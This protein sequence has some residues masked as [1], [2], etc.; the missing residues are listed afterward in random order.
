MTSWPGRSLVLGLLVLPLAVL[1]FGLLVHAIRTFALRTAPLDE[2]LAAR[3]RSVLLGHTVRQGFAW[4]MGPIERMIAAGS[5]SP[6]SLTLLG[7]AL[8]VAGSG[9]VAAGDLTVGGLVVLASSA[10]DFLDGRVARRRNVATR[11]GEFLDSTMDR[12]ADAFCFGAAAFLFRAEAWNL[13]ASLVA[14][15]AAAVVPYARAKAEALG[16]SL[17]SGLMQRPER[18]VLFS[19]AAIFSATLDRVWPSFGLSAYPSF[20]LSIWF[21][22]GATLWTAIART[23]EGFRLVG[24]RPLDQ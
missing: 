8:C 17:R 9:F 23:V 22:A 1:F 12:Y 15:G 2:E 10:F 19:V 3:G 5:V 20:A 16:V 11:A 4:L 14:F 18:L 7:F 13:A 6:D 21:L 24:G